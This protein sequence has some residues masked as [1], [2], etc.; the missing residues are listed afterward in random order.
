MRAEHPP[1]P[2]TRPCKQRLTEGPAASPAAIR[3]ILIGLS[4]SVLLFQLSI[5]VFTQQLPKSIRGY[6]VHQER[7]SITETSH[8]TADPADAPVVSVGEPLLTDL[9]LSGVSIGLPMSFRSPDQG[10]NVDFLSF[11]DFAINGISVSIEEY[12]HPFVFKKNELV[13]LPEPVMI[14]ISSGRIIQASWNELRDS[15]S[16]WLVTGRVFIFGKFK[17]FGFQFKRAI[18]VDISIRTKNPFYK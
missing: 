14:F 15:R 18:P 1:Q 17:R 4:V 10:G 7:V 8:N 9:S 11:H 12:R 13:E 5:Q 6:K 2:A 16:E 3:G